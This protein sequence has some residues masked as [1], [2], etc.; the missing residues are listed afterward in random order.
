MRG[1]RAACVLLVSL[2]GAAQSPIRV[3]DHDLRVV[4][5]MAIPKS[6]SAFGDVRYGD[7]IRL[8][9][10]GCGDPRF[11]VH[12]NEAPSLKASGWRADDGSYGTNL[13][14]TAG[15]NAKVFGNCFFM[16]EPS[17]GGSVRLTSGLSDLSGKASL[18]IVGEV[19]LGALADVLG[20]GFPFGIEAPLPAAPPASIEVELRKWLNT[21]LD[22]GTLAGT[23]WR[24]AGNKKVIPVSTQAWSMGGAAA[25]NAYFVI[26]GTIR[27]QAFHNAASPTAAQAALEEDLPI[28][29]SGN[30]GVSISTTFFSR[31]SRELLPIRMRGSA[32]YS[33]LLWKGEMPYELVL[34]GAHAE[35]I[36]HEGAGAIKL[37]LTASRAALGEPAHKTSWISPSNVV[38]SASATILLDRLAFVPGSLAFRVADFHVDLQSSFGPFGVHLSSGRLQ[39]A[40]NGGRISIANVADATFAIPAC[41]NTNYIKLKA[42]RHTC[43]D[44]DQRIGWLSFESGRQSI[45]VAVQ[46]GS[47]RL[48]ILKGRLQASL[49][50]IAQ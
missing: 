29:G 16:N 35:L 10:F 17:V 12:V 48:R 5:S 15:L 6:I 25:D 7:T 19:S 22:F 40:L 13:S 14:L 24:S 44:P 36:D 32:S 26:D 18:P 34:D 23:E 11:L 31:L 42:R 46:P 45:K 39:Q 3:A 21:S 1:L 30:I 9:E 27:Q 20:I 4:V 2:P 50:T 49:N 47:L 8:G 38:Q 41:V 28:W 43:D 37:K 33:I